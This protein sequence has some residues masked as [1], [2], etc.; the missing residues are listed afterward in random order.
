MCREHYAGGAGGGVHFAP[1]DSLGE[2]QA[3]ARLISRALQM[4]DLLLAIELH[5]RN[6]ANA[7]E[8][9]EL[10]LSVQETLE[11]LGVLPK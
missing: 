1:P 9:H 8:G 6:G 11:Y 4:R 7:R 5:V 2:R 10:R 3:N